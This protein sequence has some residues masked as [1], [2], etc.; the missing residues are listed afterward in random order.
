MIKTL[1]CAVLGLSLLGGLAS[2]PAWA[3][4]EM[5]VSGKSFLSNVEEHVIPS[6]TVP[7]GFFVVQKNIGM[8]TAPGWFDG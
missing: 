7:T 6:S 4:D 8:A 2:S 3:A 1:H 5:Q